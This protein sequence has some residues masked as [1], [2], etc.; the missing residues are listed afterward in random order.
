M[1]KI[2]LALVT[3]GLFTS[4]M[5]KDNSRHMERGN[6][7]PPEAEVVHYD[8]GEVNQTE[9]KVE[10]TD[11]KPLRKKVIERKVRELDDKK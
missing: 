7:T 5:A 1:K 4:L 6:L 10:K 11:K 2:V 3:A 9:Q 8:N